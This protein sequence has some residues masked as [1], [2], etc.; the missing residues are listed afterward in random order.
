MPNFKQAGSADCSGAGSGPFLSL[1]SCLC[2][3]LDVCW[4]GPGG[5]EFGKRNL[6]KGKTCTCSTQ[7]RY[8]HSYWWSCSCQLASCPKDLLPIS[9]N[10]LFL[11][12]GN[13]NLLNI[14]LLFDERHI[15]LWPNTAF[16]KWL[17]W[18]KNEAKKAP[19]VTEAPTL[20]R[21][22]HFAVTPFQQLTFLWHVWEF[23]NWRWRWQL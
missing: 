22:F 3:Q 20:Q 12:L 23:S 6:W 7:I 15:L 16:T 14:L 8:P 17:N 9:T 11:I 21:C 2:I 13:R 18:K 10:A 4:G 1:G 19:A 5:Q